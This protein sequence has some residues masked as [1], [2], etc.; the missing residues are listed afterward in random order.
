MAGATSPSQP[1]IFCQIARGSTSTP[2][3]HADDKVVAFQ[4]IKPSAFRHYLV[5]P[6]EHIPT[7]R[8]LQR[9]NEDYALVSH[10]LNVG[11][12]LLRRDAPQ[13]NQY[14]FGFHQPPLNSVH[15]LH[16]HCLALPFIPRWKH[17]KYLSLGP[18]G[19]FIEAEKLLEKI[20]PLSP[21]PS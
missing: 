8:D 16:L 14:R 2:L 21:I 9:R 6:V 5:I 18:L 10:M 15:H 4:D 12:T 7:V 11:Q 20:K 1:C 19:G 3:L 17:V 13:S